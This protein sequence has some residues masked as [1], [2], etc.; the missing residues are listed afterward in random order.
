M[1]VRNGK[2]KEFTLGVVLSG[3]IGGLLDELNITSFQ[4][5]ISIG[6]SSKIKT[7]RT[8]ASGNQVQG[9]VAFDSADLIV[10]RLTSSN[11]GFSGPNLISNVLRT[12]LNRVTAN[13]NLA[14]GILVQNNSHDVVVDDTVTNGNLGTGNC[15][16]GIFV[17]FGSQRGKITSAMSIGN[18][19]RGIVFDSA[20]G[21]L[22][23]ST[24]NGQRP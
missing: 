3:Q 11:N 24:A 22:E 15:E 20:N 7:D 19:I 6:N 8:V 2:I 9:W 10:D 16:C 1:T 13:D 23:R 12:R 21:R 18:G 17:G 4:S 14:G 5:G